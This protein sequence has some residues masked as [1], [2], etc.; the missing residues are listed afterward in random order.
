MGIMTT[1]PLIVDSSWLY[2]RL[3]DPNLRLLDATTFLSIPNKDGETPSLWSGQ[4]AFNEEH[5]PGAVFADMLNNFSDRN[6]PFPMTIPSREQF[7][8]EIEKLGVGE[9]TYVV[10]YDRGALANADVIASYWAS[11][12]RWQ[13][14][15]EGFDNVA[16]LDGGLVKWKLDG[17]PT[18]TEKTSYPR[19]KFNFSRRPKLVVNKEQV[20]EAIDNDSVVLIN[21]LSPADFYGETNTYPRKGHIPTSKNVFFGSLSNP[22]TRLLW[23]DEKLTEIFSKTGALDSDKS[24]ITYCGGGIAATWTAL[25]LNKLGQENVAIYDGSMNEW[26]ADPSCPLVTGKE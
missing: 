15:Y 14:K 17:Y 4:D 19:G 16:I 5:I 11:R 23:D 18:T 20:R 2:E 6:A 7:V 24:V 8:E 13:L 3:D 22:E 21:S 1:V 9:D 12:L 25:I 10:I 26:A